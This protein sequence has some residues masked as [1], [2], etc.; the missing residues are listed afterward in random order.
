VH[1]FQ[2]DERDVMVFSPVVSAGFPTGAGIF[3]R[4][5]PNLFNVA[6]TRARAALLVVGNRQAAA[7]SGVE[8]L[9]RFAA[10][11]GELGLRE[12]RDQSS[13]AS[14]GPE[15]PTVS[16]PEL[17]S[18]WEKMLYRALYQANVRT[19]PQYAVEQY[20]LDFALFANGRKLN[21]EVDGERY[22]RNWD[23]ELCRRDVIRNQRLIEL[24]WDVMR[25]WVYQVR[26]DLDGCIERVRGWVMPA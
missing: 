7:N 15:Y 12:Q 14:F 22:H 18:D 9:A 24:G 16:R 4:N 13:A 19:L 26:D 20:I 2:G 8:Y 10:Y 1:R 5:N 21:I 3:L 25:F 11:V 23:G 17:V 6:I